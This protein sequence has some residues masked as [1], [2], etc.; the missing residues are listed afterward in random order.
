MPLADVTIDHILK[1]LNSIAPFSLAEDWD[2]VGLLIGDPSAPVT[3][4]M[5]GL[6][7][8]AEL[9]DEAIARGANLLVTHHPI[10]FSALKSIRT[11]HPTGNAF[12]PE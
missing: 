2:N 7:P 10:I 9:L 12:V 3:S 5:I 11:D 8:T 6:D 4:I 1:S